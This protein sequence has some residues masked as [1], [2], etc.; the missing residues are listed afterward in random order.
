M[1]KYFLHQIKH[2]KADDT[3]DK[4]IVVKDT[5]D[6]ARQSYHA[7]LGAYGY[8]NQADTD[9]VQVEVTDMAGNRLL[10]EEWNGIE[11]TEGVE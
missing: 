11:T 4:G 3:W 6:A 1:E 7:Y 2:N 9:Y 10:F 5:L 8:G